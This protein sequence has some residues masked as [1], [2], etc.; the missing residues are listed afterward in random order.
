VYHTYTGIKCLLHRI[1]AALE[2]AESG[3]S[4]RRRADGISA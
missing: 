2:V 1:G 4:G 3:G